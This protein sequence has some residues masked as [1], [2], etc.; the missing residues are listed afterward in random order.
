M[1][2]DTELEAQKEIA[3]NQITRLQQFIDGEREFDD[4]M[5][6]DEYV[7]PVEVLANG[8]VREVKSKPTKPQS[9]KMCLVLRSA[10]SK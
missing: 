5:Q 6:V 8:K 7:V 9:V 1:V 10:E 4:A 2:F 3:D